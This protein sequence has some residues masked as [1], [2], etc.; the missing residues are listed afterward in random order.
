[1]SGLEDP[2]ELISGDLQLLEIAASSGFVDHVANTS[3]WASDTRV[4]SGSRP[5]GFDLT[6]WHDHLASA[7]NPHQVGDR[8]APT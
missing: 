2:I 4:Q 1:M 6:A 7:L 5:F 8:C 3:L